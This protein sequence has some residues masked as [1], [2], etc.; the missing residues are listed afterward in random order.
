[1]YRLE[2]FIP[3]FLGP[4]NYLTG[5]FRPKIFDVPFR[6]LQLRIIVFVEDTKTF[7]QISLLSNPLIMMYHLNDIK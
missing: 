7:L 3:G 6:F 5:F 4:E 2:N 1:M